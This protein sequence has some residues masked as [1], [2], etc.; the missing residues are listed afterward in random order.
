MMIGLVFSVLTAAGVFCDD[1]NRVKISECVDAE[2]KPLFELYLISKGSNGY[3]Y[4]APRWEL[5]NKS[6]LTVKHVSIGDKIY[7]LSNGA[8]A[9]G[10]G[11]TFLQEFLILKPGESRKTMADDI[12]ANENTRGI[13]IQS[14]E[15]PKH[16]IKFSVEGSDGKFGKGMNWDKFGTIRTVK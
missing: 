9:K 16:I 12:S 5:V 15:F 7:I 10:H 14:V 2:G 8:R 1:D 11:E 6:N 13:V 4:L 3:G